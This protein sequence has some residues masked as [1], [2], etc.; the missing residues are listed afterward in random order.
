MVKYDPACLLAQGSNLFESV[1]IM[2]ATIASQAF[3]AVSTISRCQTLQFLAQ[4]FLLFMV[5]FN[6]ILCQLV[7]YLAI[8]DIQ[9]LPLFG[10]FRGAHWRLCTNECMPKL[11]TVGSTTSAIICN[12]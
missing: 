5:I 9:M 11:A 2:M 3:K 1:E 6:T 12:F 7:P 10:N 8:L 4:C